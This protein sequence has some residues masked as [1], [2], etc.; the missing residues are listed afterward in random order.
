M[1]EQKFNEEKQS[2]AAEHARKLQERTPRKKVKP[3]KASRQW[4]SAGLKK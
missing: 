2:V 4:S 3:N 1:I